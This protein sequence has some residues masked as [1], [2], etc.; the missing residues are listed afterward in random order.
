MPSNVG[1]GFLVGHRLCFGVAIATVFLYVGFRTDSRDTFLCLAKEKYPKEMPPGFRLNPAR[2][3]FGEGFRRAI[4]GP[5]KTSG[6]LPL[7]YRAHF[8]KN[9]DARGG[10]TG[11]NPFARLK[12]VVDLDL[13]KIC[14]IPPPSRGASFAMKIGCNIAPA[15]VIISNTAFTFHLTVLRRG[16]V[17]EKYYLCSFIY[18]S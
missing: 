18:D 9:C 11:G 6:L 4:L 3:A 10:I 2:L 13:G 15:A 12:V 5:A 1:F 14:R 8:A 7:P 17:N 16:L